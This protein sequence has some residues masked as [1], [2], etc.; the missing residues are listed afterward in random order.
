MFN[1]ILKKYK[2]KPVNFEERY[3]INDHQLRMLHIEISINKQRV[4]RNFFFLLINFFNGTV[5]I[6]LAL[7]QFAD[8]NF[9]IAEYANEYNFI[10]PIVAFMIYVSAA[11]FTR[12]YL[13]SLHIYNNKVDQYNLVLDRLKQH[14]EDK[15]CPQNKGVHNYEELFKL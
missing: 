11:L 7:L 5:N 6:I 13:K 14:E 12:I 9:N 2:R 3:E 1:N 15:K 10:Q 8:K 4:Q